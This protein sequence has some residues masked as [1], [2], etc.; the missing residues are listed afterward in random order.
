MGITSIILLIAQI[1]GIL[2]TSWFLKKIH[3]YKSISAIHASISEAAARNAEKAM[4][5]AQANARIT[6][7]TVTAA[8][9][10]RTEADVFRRRAEV[11]A[12]TLKL[13]CMKLD[14]SEALKLLKCGCRLTRG[15][16][17]GADMWITLQAG[18]PDGI[19]INAN[20]AAV[21]GLA[22]GTICR[23]RPYVMMRTAQGDFVPWAAT[24]SDLLA[25]DWQ[26]VDN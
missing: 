11:S 1:A 8:E 12:H 21:T 18:Y 22:E 23:F 26:I 4:T 15:G 25:E 6:A 2:A 10:A 24:Q 7:A 20:T 17:N 19:P 9:E 14:F 5:R 13:T 16:W 3:H